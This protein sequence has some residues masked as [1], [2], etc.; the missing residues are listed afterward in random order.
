VLSQDYPGLE[1]FVIDDGSTDN[2]LAVVR[3]FHEAINVE[4]GP[5]RGA[6]YARNRGLTLSTSEFVLFLDADDYIEPESLRIWAS[7]ACDRA[8]DILFGPFAFEYDGWKKSGEPPVVPSTAANILSQW[9][10]GWFT[11]PCAVMWRR[12]FLQSIGGWDNRALRGQDGEVAC[13]ALIQRAR[14]A[15][16]DMGKGIYV[17]HDGPGR[18][19][20]RTG[21]AV[22][23]WELQ[24]LARLWRLGQAHGRCDDAAFAHAYY[25]LAREC[26]AHNVDDI[27]YTALKTARALGLKGH[28][29]TTT[30]RILAGILGL[31]IKLRLVGFLKGLSEA[32]D[33]SLAAFRS[34][35]L[36]QA[37]AS[38]CHYASVRL[39]WIGTICIKIAA[40][41]WPD[42]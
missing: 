15:T 19:S 17:Q 12:C 29:G 28:I 42:L 13:R 30:H 14:V 26:F 27:G 21:H 40:L 36:A 1:I 2:S 38:L 34:G 3:S 16:S 35:R 32:K 6:C 39:A 7:E 20:R 4:T 37:C 33:G 41:L 25:R 9:L 22:L 24:S 8:A 5:N 31:R 11:P 18:I 10:H 23:S